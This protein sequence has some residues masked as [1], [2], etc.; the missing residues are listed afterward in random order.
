MLTKWRAKP[1]Y[2]RVPKI[3][4]RTHNPN[5]NLNPSSNIDLNL[6]IWQPWKTGEIWAY[7]LGNLESFA[8]YMF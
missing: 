7:H 2:G 8:Y 6:N 4:A 5:Q 3:A 1:T